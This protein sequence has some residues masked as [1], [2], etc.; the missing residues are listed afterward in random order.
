MH[1]GEIPQG[2]EI[3]HTCRNRGCVNYGHMELVTHRVNTMR[4][5]SPHALRAAQTHCI[6]G[7]EFDERN[8]YI[9]A[10]GCRY[11]RECGRL[12]AARRREVQ[13]A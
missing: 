6:H 11:C 13:A 5:F 12:H 8:T 10:N 7:H 2:L 9:K 3:D 4:G 1:V